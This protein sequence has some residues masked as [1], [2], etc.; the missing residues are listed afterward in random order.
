MSDLPRAPVPPRPRPRPPR[1]PRAA[2]ATLAGIVVV[3]ALAALGLPTFERFVVL[4][5]LERHA[6]DRLAFEDV[7][8][9]QG[10]LWT[11][12]QPTIR[13]AGLLVSCASLTARIDRQALLSGARHAEALTASQCAVERTQVAESPD[14]ATADRTT[15]EE[16]IHQSANAA[17][18]RTRSLAIDAIVLAPGTLPDTVPVNGGPTT[19]RDAALSRDDSGWHARA[20]LRADD[21][22]ARV[23]IRSAVTP[24]LRVR[25]DDASPLTAGP[26]TARW[27][28]GDIRLEGDTLRIG[29]ARVE[30]DALGQH[31]TLHIGLLHAEP[32]Q[33]PPRLLLRGATLTGSELPAPLRDTAAAAPDPVLPDDALDDEA[34][35]ETDAEG[36]VAEDPPDSDEAAPRLS[37]E[38]R[39][40]RRAARARAARATALDRT[41]DALAL[42]RTLHRHAAQVDRIDSPLDLTIEDLRFGEEHRL[43]ID[44]FRVSPGQRPEVRGR[45]GDALIE[46]TPHADRGWALQVE[47]AAVAQLHDALASGRM[48]VTAMLPGAPA[49]VSPAEDGP[50]VGDAPA[51]DEEGSPA[52]DG[53]GTVRAIVRLAM[54]DLIIVLPALATDPVG[55]IQLAF[56]A[57]ATAHP[58]NAISATAQLT[59]GAIPLDASVHLE[60][61]SAGDTL[62]VEMGFTERTPCQAAWRSIPPGMAPT[63][64]PRGVRWTGTLR[65]RVTVTYRIGETT[66]LRLR[67]HDEP[68][69]CEAEWITPA[70][71]PRQLNDPGFVHHVREGTELADLRVGP[72]TPSFV[73]LDALPSYVPALMYLSEEMAFF[74]N[75]WISIPLLNRALRMNLERGYYV[76]GGSTVS[77][78]L[79][80]NLFL[81]REK[82][83]ARKLEEAILVWVMETRVPKNRILE[84]YLNCI[85]FGPDVFG[86]QEAARFYFQTDA[87]DL[88]PLE[89]AF[90]A[91]LKPSP[92]IGGPWRRRGESP[93][94]GWFPQR[95][96]LLLE[97][98]VANGSHIPADEVAHYAPFIVRFP[99]EGATHSNVRIRRP[100]NAPVFLFNPDDPEH[101]DGPPRPLRPSPADEAHPP[102][103]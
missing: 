93:A 69:T 101:R 98:A 12:T 17:L 64:G 78:Q 6:A 43:A 14:S 54:R 41:S 74:R 91:A 90:L 61:L 102:P 100:A 56:A 11:L 48:D 21:V 37:R 87:R 28:E 63:I 39:I 75:R 70:L 45:F 55:P 36:A 81:T 80:K 33:R 42:V 50:P 29:D 23:D 79:V 26:V 40:A 65:P 88:S 19:I 4:R 22:G 20:T 7:H 95:L 103:P 51:P 38:E 13:V 94:R 99:P 52:P 60:G 92:R 15:L 77:Q 30:L 89:A 73:P 68:A 1:W 47:N 16:R 5:L 96:E 67:T 18:A 66:S 2:I 57:D 9:V 59:L 62:T 10:D 58:D 3:V 32:R 8:R 24:G 49:P 85:E 72:G 25:I 97:R 35:F 34:G 84:L 27:V 76:Y 82:T 46:I 71:D 31:A 86:I 44:R 83:L 53:N